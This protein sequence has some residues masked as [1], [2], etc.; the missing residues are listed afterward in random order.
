MLRRPHRPPH[1]F[2]VRAI[3]TSRMR[4]ILPVTGASYLRH[5]RCTTARRG[6]GTGCHGTQ[7]NNKGGQSTRAS[8]EASVYTRHRY[9]SGRLPNKQGGR[10]R[11]CRKSVAKEHGRLHRHHVMPSENAGVTACTAAH[12]LQRVGF[13][14]P[15]FSRSSKI[16]LSPILHGLAPPVYGRPLKQPPS[17]LQTGQAPTTDLQPDKCDKVLDRIKHNKKRS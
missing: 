7:H 2:R 14:P 1:K 4:D 11:R 13:S 17:S 12:V 10:F 6:G 5:R 16:P 8:V 3:S 15:A 9:R